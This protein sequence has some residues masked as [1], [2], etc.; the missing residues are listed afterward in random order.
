[1]KKALFINADSSKP[2]CAVYQAGKAYGHA[3]GLCKELDVT[4]VELGSGE[5]LPEEDFDVG[6]FNYQHVTMQ[7]V[8]PLLFNIFP[9]TMGF[10]YEARKNPSTS[11]VHFDN[12]QAGQ[13]FDVLISPDPVLLSPNSL[14]VGTEH[15]WG[16]PRV[17]PRFMG[18]RD[19]L[20]GTVVSTFGFPSPWKDIK[21][22][23]NKMNYEFN[24]ATFRLNFA[25]ASHQEG[26]SLHQQQIEIAREI[27]G[28]ANPGIKVEVTD[29]YM[30]DAELVNWLA[31][32]SVN[33]FLSYEERGIQTG[34]ALLASADMAIASRAPLMVSDNI[35]ARHLSPL[36]ISEA[37]KETIERGQPT[38]EALYQAWSPL[39]FADRIDKLVREYLS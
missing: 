11:P 39:N 23:I 15:I 5:Q 28:M 31:Q 34:G 37:L 19:A 36:M 25:P 17:I 6:I 30:E 38:V 22:V 9:T 33:V 10:L 26:M 24:E 4:Y 32:S 7:C 29:R 12:L 14:M 13:L 27:A 16:A 20:P 18:T 8:P 1:M 3:F 2:H 21:T 35:E